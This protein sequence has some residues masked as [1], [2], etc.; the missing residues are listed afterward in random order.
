MHM[1]VKSV[2]N[3]FSF[4]FC[5]CM[6]WWMFGLTYCDNYFLMYTSQ[7]YAVH[8]KLI[9]QC[10]NHTAVKLKKKTLFWK[11]QVKK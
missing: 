11:F 9:Q 6:S 8:L 4:L 5:I 3:F 7:L 2:K 10:V 1:K